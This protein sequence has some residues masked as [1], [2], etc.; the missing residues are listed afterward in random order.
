MQLFFRDPTGAFVCV[1]GNVDDT[2]LNVLKKCDAVSFVLESPTAYLLSCCGRN[3]ES[4]DLT[5]EQLGIQ[6]NSVICV[7]CRL[8]GGMM[9]MVGRFHRSFCFRSLT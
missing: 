5:L 7:N 6:N 9:A 3:I 8:L 1:D 2:I 4:F